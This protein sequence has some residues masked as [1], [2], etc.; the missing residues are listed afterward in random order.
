MGGN[1]LGQTTLRWSSRLEFEFLAKLQ[2]LDSSLLSPVMPPSF[3]T[4][5]SGL[6]E[7]QVQA[8]GPI[9]FPAYQAQ[10]TLRDGHLV[11]ITL[12][13]ANFHLKGESAEFQ[14]F[15]S[16][17]LRAHDTIFLDGNVVLEKGR[18]VSDLDVSMQ[19][20]ATEWNGWTIGAQ[21]TE[22]SAIRKVDDQWGI[23][24]KQ[25]MGEATR[26]GYGQSMAMEFALDSVSDNNQVFMTVQDNGEMVGYK[27]HFEF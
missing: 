24:F 9:C 15:D 2:G 4:G 27:K 1:L 18:V 17:I 23:Q 3:A 10:L 12:K 25:L 16:K 14:V 20:Q 19:G 11:N 22:I 13:K 26:A 8:S 21:N 7:G 5:L 6:I